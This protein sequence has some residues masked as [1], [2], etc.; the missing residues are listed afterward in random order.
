MNPPIKCT[1]PFFPI[2]ETPSGVGNVVAYCF[3]FTVNDTRMGFVI[4]LLHLES[5]V[6]GEVVGTCTWPF[7]STHSV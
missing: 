5:A 4:F 7:V 2:S 1:W 6:G 3:F